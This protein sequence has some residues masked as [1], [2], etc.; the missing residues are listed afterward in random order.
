MRPDKHRHRCALISEQGAHYT[1]RNEIKIVA[2][3]CQREAARSGRVGCELPLADAE[4]VG[5]QIDTNPRACNIPFSTC[6]QRQWSGPVTF[7]S[8]IPAPSLTSQPPSGVFP[9]QLVW[10]NTRSN[11]NPWNNSGSDEFNEVPMVHMKNNGCSD[12]IL[13]IVAPEGVCSVAIAFAPLYCFIAFAALRCCVAIAR[14][15]CPPHRSH[16]R[17][18]KGRPNASS[19]WIPMNP[20]RY[21]WYT[22]CTRGTCKGF[23]TLTNTTVWGEG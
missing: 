15:A 12:D 21:H 2:V 19:S 16:A 23:D 20:S 8:G 7:H 10:T 17:E 9:P 11:E 13:V 3:V 18:A 1:L 22:M 6:V 5:H 4:T 14:C